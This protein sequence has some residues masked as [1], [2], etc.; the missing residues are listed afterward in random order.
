MP[1]MV[2]RARSAVDPLQSRFFS[3]LLTP[4]ATLL[5]SELATLDA[6][7]RVATGQRPKLD[8]YLADLNSVVQ[9]V[10]GTIKEKEAELSA[11]IAAN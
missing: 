2:V 7:L 4:V 5:L 10:A 8:A 3:K 1:P 11:A 6:E 9:Q